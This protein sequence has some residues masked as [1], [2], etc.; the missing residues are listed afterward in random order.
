MYYCRECLISIK[1]GMIVG[2][3]VGKV[4]GVICIIVGITCNGMY[5]TRHDRPNR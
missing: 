3:V 5:N 4:V 1:S 2:V